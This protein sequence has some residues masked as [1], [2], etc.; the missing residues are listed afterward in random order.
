MGSESKLGVLIRRDVT[1]GTVHFTEA[2]AGFEEVAAVKSIFG[3]RTATVLSDL[4]VD[5]EDGRGY[6]RINDE[7]GSIIVNVKYLQSGDETHLYLDVVHELVHIRQHMEGKELW[8]RRY[9]YVDRPTEIEA[10]SVV[11]NEAR[12]LGLGSKEII[13]YLKV[14]WVTDEEFKRFL[15]TLG[16]A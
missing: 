11:L 9:S 8:D 14:D 10:Y 7:K 2:F 15:K 4:M 16:M 13:E 5:I 3:G 12:R 1:L 6:M